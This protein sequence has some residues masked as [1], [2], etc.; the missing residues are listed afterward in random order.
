VESTVVTNGG[1][2]ALYIALQS[3][4]NPG[5][6]LLAGT[7]IAPN[8][9]EMVEFIG[10]RVQRMPLDLERFTA[11]VANLEQAEGAV[12]LIASPSPITGMAIQPAQMSAL[13]TTALERGMSVIVDRSLA[14]CC[15]ESPAAFTD[16]DL[17]ARVLTTG[18]FSVAHSMSGWR[19]GYFT[20]TANH[21]AEMRELKQAMSICT[22]AIS[23]Y[24]A[25]AAIDGP[26]EA[27]ALRREEARAR[28]D[29]LAE[30]AARRGFAVAQAD[31]WPPLLLD[32]RAIDG[33]QFIAEPASLYAPELAEYVRIDL[34]IPATT[35]DALLE[36]LDSAPTV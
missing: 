10:A 3:T 36:H 16:P 32:R 30:A 31:A 6:T 19:V 27:V 23:Q 33:T 22:S 12:L 9:V 1:A 8:I 14:W 24:A 21:L 5:D 4:L 17:G 7:P 35:F 18:S 34:R 11:S 26:N 2:E 25:L 29:A 28:R 15:Y 20:A 13:V